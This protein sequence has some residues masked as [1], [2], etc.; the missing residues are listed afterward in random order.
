MI[1]LQAPLSQ[2]WNSG[3]DALKDALSLEANVTSKIRDIIT[4]CENPSDGSGF[5][6]DHVCLIICLLLLLLLLTFENFA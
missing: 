2:S 5:N 4:A 3:V 1:V 6:D